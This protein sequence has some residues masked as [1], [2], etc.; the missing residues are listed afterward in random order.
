M[1]DRIEKVIELKS[2]ISRVWRAVTDHEEFG[3]WFRVKLDGPFAVGEVSRGRITHPGYEHLKWQAEVKVMEPERLFS[4]TWCP[5]ASD[6]DF[7]YENEPQ[8]LVEFRLEPTSSGTR[9]VVTESGFSA[10]PDEPRRLDALRENT[11]GWNEQAKN[12]IAHVNS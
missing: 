12:I 7:D 9:L 6:D 1:Q 8:T 3:Q 10:L 4:F 5:Y 2:P 11:G